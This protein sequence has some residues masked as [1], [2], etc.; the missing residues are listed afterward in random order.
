MNRIARSVQLW[1]V[2]SLSV[3][4][5]GLTAWLPT[6][7]SNIKGNVLEVT[8]TDL[9]AITKGWAITSLAVDMII[10]RAALG[11]IE[12][13]VAPGWYAAR[14]KRCKCVKTRTGLR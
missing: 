9:L 3:C 13:V 2:I 8:I 5:D 1:H 6:S 7:I 12:G 14:T 10:L 4:Y 11:D